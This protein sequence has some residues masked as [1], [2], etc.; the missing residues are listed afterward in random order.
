MR[1]GYLVDFEPDP[2]AQDFGKRYV[3]GSKPEDALAYESREEGESTCNVLRKLGVTIPKGGTYV[4][5]DFKVEQRS[6]G[7]FVIWCEGPFAWQ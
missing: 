1:K 6:S 7:D 3:F 2:Q 4:C 5:R